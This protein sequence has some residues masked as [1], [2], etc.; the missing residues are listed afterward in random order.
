MVGSKMTSSRREFAKI[1]SASALFAT[2]GCS[3]NRKPKKM[4]WTGR[5]PNVVVVGAGIS[6]LIAG[7]RLVEAGIDVTLVENEPQVGGRVYSEE[8][9]GVAANLGA[10]YFFMSDNDYLNHYVRRAAKFIPAGQHG[11]LWNGEFVASPDDRFFAQLPI[12]EA[13]FEDLDAATKKI[14]QT[15][16]GLAIGREYIFDQEPRSDLWSELDRVS[17][18][19]L[20]SDYHPD[21][22]N[23]YNC[24]LKPEGGVGASG[25]SALLLVGLYGATKGDGMSYL[26]EGG[27]QTVAEAIASDITAGGGTIVLSVGAERIEQSDAGVMVQCSNGDVLNADY[28]I[29]T[30]PTTVAVRIVTE[31]P[32]EK[33]EALIALQYGASMQVGLHLTNFHPETN[34]ASS[35]FHNESVNAYMSQLK[36]PRDGEAIIS[37]N[38]SGEDAQTLTDESIVNRVSES[39]V[40]VHPSFDPA[41]HVASHSVKKWRDGIAMFP[42]GLSTDRQTALRA[43]VGKIFFGGDY[44][45]NPALDGAAWSGVRSADQV[46]RVAGEQFAQR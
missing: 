25:T 17:A 9:G 39:L 43:P 19:E 35:I 23:F 29:V 8:L 28:A 12:E 6:G 3:A 32:Q 7:V 24:F 13:A 22:T 42:A 41:K 30:T 20:L 33:R 1:L 37:I 38:I 16:K 44:T 4:D 27:N 46:L 14:Q 18:S 10:Q 21:V 31:L 26:I 11:A 40:K 15:Y 5:K 2:F 45:H 34:V 36:R